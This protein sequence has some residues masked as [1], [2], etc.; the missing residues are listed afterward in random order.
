M[1]LQHVELIFWKL[2][3]CLC[4]YLYIYENIYIHT[5]IAP[6][7]HMEHRGAKHSTTCQGIEQDDLEP[8][9]LNSIAMI[10]LE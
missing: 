8:T 4:I 2:Y 3:H 1:L 7:E 6:M 5:K 9:L 10:L